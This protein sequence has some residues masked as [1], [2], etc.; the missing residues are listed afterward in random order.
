VC[1]QHGGPTVSWAASHGAP[2]RVLS[3]IQGGCGAVGG[4]PEEGHKDDQRAG[5][6]LL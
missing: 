3:P 5:A 2:S 6:P 1:S 4:G